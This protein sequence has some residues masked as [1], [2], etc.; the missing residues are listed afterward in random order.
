MKKSTIFLCA[1]C[2]L[3][4]VSAVQA[5]P[6]TALYD[7]FT[8]PLLNPA[9][10]FG[11]ESDDARA[12]LENIRYIVGN[13]TLGNRLRLYSRG[14]GASGLNLGTRFGN[15][16]LNFRN[17]N[18]INA[19]KASVWANSTTVT[20]CPGNPDVAHVRSR[21]GGAFFN[22]SANPIPGDSTYDVIAQ[23]RVQRVSNS[24][25]APNVVRVRYLVSLCQDINCL[26]GPTLGVGE[27]GPPVNPGQKVTLSVEWDKANKRF[28]FR[29]DALAPAIFKY[30]LPDNSTPGNNFKNLQLGYFVANCA[31]ATP[32]I[33][34][35][36]AYFDDVY[37]NPLPAA[38]AM[39]A[40]R[41]E[42][43]PRSIIYGGSSIDAA[44]P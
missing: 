19:I 1:I 29:R 40:E 39:S 16:V 14:Y 31:S 43:D 10:W 24:I 23:I 2:S 20:G 32:P 17:P 3:T 12:N 30:T 33:A 9:K 38:S 41:E 42:I 11:G 13:P 7:N 35:M 4:P 8:A 25:D 15:N 37:T 22:A 44:G 5:A 6:P 27:I 34:A 26:T 21:L 36:D 28:I 18:S